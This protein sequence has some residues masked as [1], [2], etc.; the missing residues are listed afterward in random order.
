MITSPRISRRTIGLRSGKPFQQPVADED[1]RD[2]GGHH[3]AELAPRHI[4]PALQEHLRRIRQRQHAHDHRRIRKRQQTGQADAAHG[5]QAE[6]EA[7]QRLRIGGGACQHEKADEVS[8]RHRL[9]V[10]Q[11]GKQLRELRAGAIEDRRLDRTAQEPLPRARPTNVSA[12]HAWIQSAPS[13]R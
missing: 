12:D 5:D 4:A 7:R 1:H 13:G 6:G 11:A 10:P 8:G 2:A 9:K 3:E